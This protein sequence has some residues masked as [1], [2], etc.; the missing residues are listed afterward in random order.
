MIEAVVGLF[1]DEADTLWVV[2]QTPDGKQAAVVMD[3]IFTGSLNSSIIHAWAKNA[4]DNK[5]V[6]KL[7]NELKAAVA[8]LRDMNDCRPLADITYD[9]RERE[10]AGWNG[11]RVSLWSDAVAR[12]EKLMEKHQ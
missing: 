10:G 6:E 5:P 7:R 8:I 3:S 12:A 2:F 11:P 1:K 4:N 9:I